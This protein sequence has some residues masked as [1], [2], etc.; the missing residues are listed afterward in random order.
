MTK[1]WRIAVCAVSAIRSPDGTLEIRGQVHEIVERNED[2]LGEF[3]FRLVREEIGLSTVTSD[4]GRSP[5]DSEDD[6]VIEE[7]SNAVRHAG[8]PMRRFQ[9]AESFPPPCPTAQPTSANPS[10][11]SRA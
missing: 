7:D 4:G 1:E 9:V 11:R 8:R 10:A 6:D 3:D 2:D 5:D